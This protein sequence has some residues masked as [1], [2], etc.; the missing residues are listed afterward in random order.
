MGWTDKFWKP[1]KLA[2]G[3]VITNLADARALM[4]ALPQDKRDSLQW[5]YTA[6]VLAR[7]ASSPSVMD[8]ALS[9]TLAALKGDGLVRGATRP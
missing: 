8:E 9:Q 2:D 7:A 5:R 1:I 4:A 6:E 3:R